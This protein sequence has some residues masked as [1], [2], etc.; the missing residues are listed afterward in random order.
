MERLKEINNP[1]ELLR[2]M[3]DIQ[4]KWMDKNGILHSQLLPEMY[5]N[6]SM[7]SPSDVVKTMCGICVDQCELERFWF[8]N[9]NYEFRILKIEIIRGDCSPGHIFLMY[10]DNG[11]YYWFENAWYDE[12]GIHEYDD[13]EQLMSDVKE[14]FIKQNQIDENELVNLNITD[15]PKYP[16][17]ISYE[18]MD[19]LDINIKTL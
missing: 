6:Y 18:D 8:S 10:K 1:Y 5:S 12:R 9:N 11:K 19:K 7:M 4:Y 16:Y 17:H 15:W 13:Y 3:S 14:K 2:F